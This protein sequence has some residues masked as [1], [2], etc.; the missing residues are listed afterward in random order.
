MQKI[1]EIFSQTRPIDRPIEKVIDY[2]ASDQ[3]R[4]EREV[5]EYEVTPSVERGMRRILEAFDE[6][7]RGGNVTEIGVWVSGFYGS[8][9]SSFTKYLGFA[10][11]PTQTVRNAPFFESLAARIPSLDL[12][13]LLKTIAKKHRT[14]VFM[15]DLGTDQLADSASESVANVIYWNVLKSL[16]FS[17]EKKVAELELRLERDN[18]LDEF[19]KAYAT[20]YPNKEPW[21]V[22]H[23]DPSLAVVRA[24]TL[25]PS[26]YPDEYKG[27]AEF[28]QLQTFP[29][30]SVSEIAERMIDLI[31]R[32]RKCD[33]IIFFV[34]EVGQYVA[35]RQE[36]I[37]NL[38]GFA[39][40]L[41]EQG[42]GHVWFVA[43]AQQTL[44]EISEKASLN[45][46]ELFKLKDRFPIAVPLES[47][48]IRDITA[49]RLLTK[50][51]EGRE[52]LSHQFAMHGELLQMHT[53]L[54]EWPG[55][56]AAVHA[57]EFA[58]L[59]PFL[60]TRFDLVL[61]LIRAL[62]RRTGGTG[63]RSA[64]RL[65][66]DL[67]VDNSHTLPKGTV[68]LADRPIGRLAAADDLYDTLRHDLH[69]EHP[70]AVE[71]V[72]RIAKHPDFK[73][74]LWALRAAKAV[75]VLQ[76]LELYPRTAE[77]IAALLY[78]E[79]GASGDADGVRKALH[80]LVDA[81]EF[82]LVELRADGPAQGGVGFV[83]LSD[84][85]QPIQKKRD[86]Y[87]PPQAEINGARL[88]ILR[89][90]FDPVPEV[91]LENTKTI[92]AAL[93]L[94]KGMVAGETG[95]IAFR[96]EE[97]DPSALKARISTLE[98]QTQARDDEKNNVF[99]LFER[100]LDAE[101][102]LLD[103]CRSTYIQAEGARG[104]DRDKVLHADVNRFLR[105]EERRAERAKDAART[106]YQH[107]LL[108]G[109]FV[110][111]G[112]RRAVEELGT[113]V[114]GSATAF[115]HEVAGVVFRHYSLVKRSLAPDLA[116]R[117]LNL[118]R[119]D[120]LS[121]EHD[122]LGI[123]QTKG[124][125]VSIH[126]GHP[127]L[128]ET[129]RAFRDLVTASGSG[130]V[131]GSAL[132]DFF[133]APPYGWSKDTTRYL[134]AALLLAG[135]VELHTGDGV[136]RT[137]GPKASEAVRN[138]QNFN[139]IGVAPRNQPVPVEALDRAS[140]RLEEMFGLEVLPLEDQ[141]S[142]VVRTH[143]PSVMERVGSLPDRLRLLKLPGE[144]RA[145]KFL[146]ACADLLKED[147]GGA[148]S[149][150][151]GAVCSL[152]E[153]EKWASD[154]VKILDNGGEQD[155][156][157]A[158]GTTVRLKAL[159]ELFPAVDELRLHPAAAAINEI[160]DSETFHLRMADLRHA[161]R[162]LAGAVRAFHDA[163]R[164][165]LFDA[166]SQAQRRL[167]A[168]PAWVRVPPEDQAEIASE[169]TPG[170][171]SEE[172]LDPLDV[173]PR[174]L[175]RQIG[176]ADLEERL[177]RRLEERQAMLELEAA[178]VAELGPESSEKE[179]TQ[180]VAASAKAS[181]AEPVAIGALLPNTVLET[182]DEVNQW[183]DEL[184]ERLVER[185]QFGPIR[186]TEGR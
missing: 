45:S 149:L 10:L 4:L 60:P 89:R 145:R 181:R 103:V 137:A 77:N 26:F 55:G 67:L 17:R 134:F 6:G 150:L 20:R 148:A 48:D 161:Q 31:R 25:V 106:S 151:G 165:R 114:I 172:P 58:K 105:S 111:R 73:D 168:R 135:E 2:R 18:R 185:V 107:A 100:P 169:L 123:R 46:T 52:F 80:R 182:V 176:L 186:L 38:D 53:H 152:P 115:L 12:R 179:P 153:E 127:A 143:F 119:L 125:R 24:S 43:T 47:T 141:V 91:R 21:D 72:T 144:E 16:G 157:A 23:D 158:R 76:P 37:L 7:A 59:Y 166:L 146:Q 54:A 28:R 90:V 82:G 39:R 9:K 87:P 139:R 32:R 96:L 138:T 98:T 104:K 120:K 56:R 124:G 57:D 27:P 130:R 49:K 147:A 15:I 142:R 8:G 3:T 175:T 171:L 167:Q 81:R 69:K 36:L 95:D 74:D 64:I 118:D 71:A 50:N 113:S 126:V 79:L 97:V 92:Q 30:L 68:P 33:N 75:A 51:N 178:R 155:L 164:A 180:A 94:G 136:L 65:V 5:S 34:D 159:A 1:R 108:K 109:V 117:W 86:A 61:D 102:H 131:Q 156:D 177:A 162:S 11:D 132:L 170:G 78:Q 70:Q 110:F 63:L 83:F 121:K 19:K 101:D 42:K 122:P 44:Q 173:L 40:A 163:A 160:V 128:E 93:R 116:A 184:R 88:E 85:V 41:K 183:I 154:V 14:A 129:L 84:E 62:S 29:I 112:R 22:I 133:N 99:W 35:P 140:R 66:Q 174:V 13:E